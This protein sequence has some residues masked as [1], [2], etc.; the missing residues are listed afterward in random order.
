MPVALMTDQLVLAIEALGT[1]VGTARLMTFVRP[2][3]EMLLDVAFQIGS[4]F[5]FPSAAFNELAVMSVNKWIVYAELMAATTYCRCEYSLAPCVQTWPGLQIAGSCIGG[6]SRYAMRWK[7]N[8]VSYCVWKIDSDRLWYGSIH[9]G[10]MDLDVSIKSRGMGEYGLTAVMEAEIEFLRGQGC[11]WSGCRTFGPEIE[12]PKMP[13]GVLARQKKTLPD[14]SI[15][16]IMHVLC[17]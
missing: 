12:L 11:G 6:S 4:A 7:R 10:E 9:V 1:I 8:W 3:I 2:E 13:C 5:K 14:L 17:R 16:A 15:D